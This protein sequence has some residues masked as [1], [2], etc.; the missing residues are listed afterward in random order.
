MKKTTETVVTLENKP[1]AAKPFWVDVPRPDHKLQ[2]TAI[3]PQDYLE[4]FVEL[5]GY[6]LP[7]ET[8]PSFQSTLINYEQSSQDFH[9]PALH[10]SWCEALGHLGTMLSELG[11]A[12]FEHNL[13]PWWDY[14]IDEASFIGIN[15]AI[16]AF[17]ISQIKIRQILIWDGIN[18]NVAV[19]GINADD[20]Q[21]NSACEGES[22]L[23]SL[24]FKTD[25]AELEKIRAESAGCLDEYLS[26][27]SETCSLANRRN[28]ELDDVYFHLAEARRKKKK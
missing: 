2:Y 13:N 11:N 9:E 19:K 7:S 22:E 18:G 3:N 8:K 14:G 20:Q 15:R 5:M 10:E 1:S 21:A 16:E 4:T 26:D 6:L 28:V 12:D 25:I 24:S 17:C 27:E 23:G